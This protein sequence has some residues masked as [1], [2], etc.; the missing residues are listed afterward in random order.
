MDT[1]VLED[2][3]FTN[4]EIKVYISLLELGT[5]T[6]GP[7][8][9]KSGLQ[10]SVVHMTLNRLVEKGFATF[11]KEGQRNH[12]QASDPKHIEDYIEDKKD[13]FHAI[14]PQLLSKQSMAKEKPETITFRSFKGIREMLQILLEA[15]G[16]RHLTISSSKESLRMGEEWWKSYHRKRAAKG[17]DASLIFNE[18][19]RSWSAETKYNKTEVRY[20]K[21]GFEPLTETII[22]ND[23]VGII[24]W[25]EKPF[26]ILIHNKLVADSYEKFFQLLWKQAKP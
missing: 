9:E 3:G 8:I 25:S 12:Y 15:G 4:A 26:G 23:K 19:L 6:A 18:S 13:Q 1:S 10:S 11:V 14:L 24:I 16:K 20:T 17:I 21:Q 22:R 7:I 5:S 2:L